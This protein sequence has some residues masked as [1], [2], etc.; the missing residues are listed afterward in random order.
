MIPSTLP[1]GPPGPRPE[2]PPTI[3]LDDVMRRLAALSDMCQPPEHAHVRGTV[4][5]VGMEWVIRLPECKAKDAALERL[6]EAAELACAA[7]DLA[8]D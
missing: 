5:A 7:Y 2:R 3:T 8:A 6:A 1:T 4:L